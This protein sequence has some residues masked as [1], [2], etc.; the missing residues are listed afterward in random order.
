MYQYN[1]C[2]FGKEVRKDENNQ[3]LSKTIQLL[4]LFTNFNRSILSTPH[5]HLIIL[6]VLHASLFFTFVTL[7][8]VIILDNTGSFCP[9][10][11]QYYQLLIYLYEITTRAR[12][13][14]L[15]GMSIFGNHG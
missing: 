8:F 11:F 9:N 13:E 15:Y 10:L 5:G 4:S 14:T 1:F 6:L 12:F 7:F 3:V 2:D